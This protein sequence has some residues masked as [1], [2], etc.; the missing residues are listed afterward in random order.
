MMT[1]ALALLALLLLATP[2]HAGWRNLLVSLPEL[3]GEGYYG[4]GQSVTV[5]L[6]TT[7]EA[8]PLP[9]YPVWVQVGRPTLDGHTLSSGWLWRTDQDGAAVLTVE[10]LDEDLPGTWLVQA[11]LLQALPDGTGDGD[12]VTFVISEGTP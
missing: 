4:P 9:H 1:R 5:Y 10:L 11:F 3:P 8:R 7:W 2:A 6:S 12:A